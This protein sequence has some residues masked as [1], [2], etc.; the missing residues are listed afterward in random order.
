MKPELF[1]SNV[2]F[3]EK[4]YVGKEE[5]LKELINDNE[6]RNGAVVLW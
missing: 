2:V 4:R 1:G 6:K 5:G 3:D